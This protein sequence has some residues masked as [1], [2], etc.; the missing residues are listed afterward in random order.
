MVS[1]HGPVLL[2][3]LC[4][5]FYCRYRFHKT[6]VHRTEERPHGTHV[7][8]EDI[9]VICLGAIHPSDLREYLEGP[10]MVVEVHDRDRKSDESSCRPTLFGEEPLDSHGNIQSFISSKETEDNPFQPQNKTWDSH[11]V[12]RVS[13]MDLFLGH[14]YLN[15]VVPIQ[16]C[17]P[18]ATPGLQGSQCRR[19]NLMPAGNYLE[20]NSLLKLR[21][22]VAVPLRTW[23][24]AQG[25]D[26]LG[27]HFG[28]IMFVFSAKE[29]FLL[30]SLLKDITLIN[31]KALELDS[32]PTGTV[33][34]ILPAF[35]MRVNIQHQEHLDI[36]TGF[37][38]LDG[39]IHLFV[40]E[41]LADGGLRQLWK[42]H[43]SQIPMLELR[44][45]KVIYNSQLLICHRLYADLET[46]LHHVH[47]FKPL[48]LLMRHPGL[49]LRNAIPHKAFQELARIYNICYHSTKF[50]EV[51]IRDLL[52]SSTMIKDLSQEFGLPI[53]QEDLMDQK[54]PIISPQPTPNIEESQSHV[55]TLNSKILAHQ[56]KYLQWRNNMLLMTREGLPD[57]GQDDVDLNCPGQGCPQLQCH[58]L[59]LH[60]ACQEGTV[61]RDWPRCVTVPSETMAEPGRRF[62]YSQNYLSAIVEPQDSQEEKKAQEKSRQAWLRVTGFQVTGLHGDILHQ[63]FPLPAIGEF[64]EE[65]QEHEVLNHL[66]YPMLHRGQWS[67]DRRHLDFEL[68]K[69]P[70]PFLEVPPPP[71]WKPVAGN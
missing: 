42:N 22:D 44:K 63:D 3:R 43:Q 71:T 35:K 30:H 34:Q 51:I 38:L 36:L 27:S 37:H 4:T 28:H 32:Y 64:H 2:Q 33:Q 21:V 66:L 65:W 49:Y 70:L 53:S 12:T 25:V 46:V 39:N 31:A 41:G 56:E 50:R 8:F 5:P 61:S 16:R 55:S 13:F 68:Y 7:Y 52:P 45:Y 60:C 69:K 29:L 58:D 9:N 14:K 59:Q 6:L 15:L 19:H 47:L 54:L 62:T 1:G 40:L 26:F 10:P 57:Q 23:A 24:K 48:S 20:A 11:G 18:K 17:E 67:W